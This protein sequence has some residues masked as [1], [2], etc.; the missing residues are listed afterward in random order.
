[1]F[2][3]YKYGF[4][5]ETIKALFN[6]A[7]NVQSVNKTG[8]RYA[9]VNTN[10]NLTL[11]VAFFGALATIALVLFY[12][13]YPMYIIIYLGKLELLQ[14]TIIPKIDHTKPL[15][16]KITLVVH[17]VWA[18]YVVASS[19]GFY[20]MFLLLTAFYKI[21]IEL[22]NEDLQSMGDMYR[23]SKFNKR[24]RRAKFQNAC[25]A[26]SDITR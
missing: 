18:F 10:L 12:L 21:F 9:I 19:F 3:L 25:V 7:K 16:F 22:L 15:G 24:Y 26:F 23:K 17:F 14:N 11:S 5:H 2:R 6:A 1:M 13:A 20:F 4:G 8:I